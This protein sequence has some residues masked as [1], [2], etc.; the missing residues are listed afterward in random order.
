[1]CENNIYNKKYMGQ[2][3]AVVQELMSVV[4]FLHLKIVREKE[5]VGK[6]F[7]PFISYYFGVSQKI[8]REWG[9]L[10]RKSNR[11]REGSES[12]GKGSDRRWFY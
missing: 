11:K 4:H 8:E 2:Y 10:Q 12:E 9:L 5:K 3:K 1:M 6:L 7:E